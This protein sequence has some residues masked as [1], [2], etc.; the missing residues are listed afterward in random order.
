M[1]PACCRQKQ[2][3]LL[4]VPHQ[5]VE[6]QMRIPRAVKAL[7]VDQQACGAIIVCD[8]EGAVHDAFE[9]CVYV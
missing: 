3:I 1:H 4:V 5:L 8:G 6:K 9:L 7:Q 2:V